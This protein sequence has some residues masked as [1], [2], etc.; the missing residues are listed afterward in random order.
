MSTDNLSQPK[1][2]SIHVYDDGGSSATV[3][4]PD[5]ATMDI[6][7]PKDIMGDMPFEDR[8]AFTLRY[9][10]EKAGIKTP[11]DNETDLSHLYIYNGVMY[12]IR[13]VVATPKQK[14][15]KLPVKRMKVCDSNLLEAVRND[16]NKIMRKHTL[17]FL[18]THQF[19]AE[20]DLRT[21]SHQQIVDILNFRD[22]DYIFS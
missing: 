14:N 4:M 10:K 18:V 20:N 21:W 12:P 3:T 8:I 22:S 19:L 5:G 9:C 6:K 17:S 16:P 7:I 2:Y 1:L 11:T 15:G 13:W